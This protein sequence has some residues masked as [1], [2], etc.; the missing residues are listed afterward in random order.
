MS[1]LTQVNF[2]MKSN[3]PRTKKIERNE[4]KSPVSAWRLVQGVPR[5]SP[6]DGWD[7]LSTHTMLMFPWLASVIDVIKQIL[8][9]VKP[10]KRDD[11][12]VMR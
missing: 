6:Y 7:G 5:V 12:E 9:S 4:Q 1:K 10:N 8:K 11:F 3:Y 2:N